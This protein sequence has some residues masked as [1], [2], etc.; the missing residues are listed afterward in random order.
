MTNPLTDGACP[1]LAHRRLANGLRTWRAGTVERGGRRRRGAEAVRYALSHMVKAKLARGWA[2][3][4]HR[5]RDRDRRR[6]DARSSLAT[7]GRVS[8]ALTQRRVSGLRE[9]LLVS[10]CPASSVVHS[11][12]RQFAVSSSPLSCVVV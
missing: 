7:L 10:A 3:W 8:A 1:Q 5:A 6:A 4:L 2:A 12:R 9:A 11:F